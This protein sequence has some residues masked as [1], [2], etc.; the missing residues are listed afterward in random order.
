MTAHA[1]LPAQRPT[2]TPG[3]T[4]RIPRRAVRPPLTGWLLL[5]S[6]YFGIRFVLRA[7]LRSGE[8]LAAFRLA[9]L[10]IGC[11]AV[12]ILVV[13]WISFKEL[14]LGAYYQRYGLC[15]VAIVGSAASRITATR[16]TE[17]R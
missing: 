6:K 12:G 16:E 1:D 15:L 10:G 5:R 8:A 11:V 9:W 17:D 2:A 7:W 13:G 4:G 14:D 3:W